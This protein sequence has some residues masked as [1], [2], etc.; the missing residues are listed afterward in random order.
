MSKSLFPSPFQ[1]RRSSSAFSQHSTSER[2]PLLSFPNP[3]TV[4]DAASTPKRPTASSLHNRVVIILVLLVIAIDLPAY[5]QSVPRVRL[6]EGIYCKNY[7][8]EH[9]PSV[10]GPGGMVPEAYCK[11]NSIQKELALLRGWLTFFDYAPGG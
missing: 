2:S 10:I 9:D 8:L 5:F 4:N 7:Y 1:R 6:L 11:L 3:A